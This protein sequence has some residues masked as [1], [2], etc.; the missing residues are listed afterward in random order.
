MMKNLF[1]EIQHLMNRVAGSVD[2]DEYIK[3]HPRSKKQPSDP[4]FKQKTEGSPAAAPKTA[5]TKS[6]PKKSAPKKSAPKPIRDIIDKLDSN[7]K[8]RF[9][10]YNVDSKNKLITYQPYEGG[11]EAAIKEFF[12][13]Y[14]AALKG[15]SVK[16][17]DP[18]WGNGEGSVFSIG[19][20]PKQKSNPKQPQQKSNPKQPQQK[21]NPKQPQQKSKL[22]DFSDAE[23]E[24]LGW[25]L[26]AIKREQVPLQDVMQEYASKSKWQT[27]ANSSAY[28]NYK[29]DY[30]KG[31]VKNPIGPDL[32]KSTSYS[33]HV[34]DWE[35][36]IRGG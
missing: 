14:G 4:M 20:Q 28:K 7:H 21:S 10:S 35:K 22:E 36:Y 18:H 13:Q 11:G 19:A 30:L 16:I 12:N 25:D 24:D 29:S 9:K 3:A 6:A 33:D 8:T 32:Q 2:Y 31:L 23:I 26:S 5:P 17:G 27:I 15:W 34:A 1:N